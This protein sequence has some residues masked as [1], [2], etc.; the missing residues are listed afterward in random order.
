M[1]EKEFA[2]DDCKLYV[3]CS[4]IFVGPCLKI[5]SASSNRHNQ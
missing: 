3:F 5:A 4:E 1:Y 2:K